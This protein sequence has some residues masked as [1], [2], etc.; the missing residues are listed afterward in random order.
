GLTSSLGGSDTNCVI[1]D[2]ESIAGLYNH[3][4]HEFQRAQSAAQES[5]VFADEV[6]GSIPD[7]RG[8]TTAQSPIIAGSVNLGVDL[9]PDDAALDTAELDDAY[10]AQLNQQFVHSTIRGDEDFGEVDEESHDNTQDDQLE[11]DDPEV[12][13]PPNT[14]PTQYP[15]SSPESDAHH[16]RTDSLNNTYVRVVHINGVHH[17][18]VLRCG[19]NGETS[20]AGDLLAGGLVPTSFKRFCTFFT[21]SV[22]DDFQLSNL[23]CKTSAYQYWNKLSWVGAPGISPHDLDDFYRELRRLSRSWRWLKK[24]VWSGYAHDCRKDIDNPGPGEL[25]LFCSTCPQ[26]GINLPDHWKDDQN[27]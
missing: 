13:S 26:D 23:E 25:A 27:K 24:L 7:P 10:M 12:I 1:A 2:A 4:D 9:I 18:P 17:I 22:L 3:G 20:I 11:S 21:T 5:A 6:S 19:C 14:L 8:T 15:E 16:P